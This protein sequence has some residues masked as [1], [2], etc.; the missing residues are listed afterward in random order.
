MARRLIWSDEFNEPGTPNPSKWTHELGAGGWGNQELQHYTN[1]LANAQVSNGTLK[2]NAI[3]ESFSGSDYT[4]ARLVTK[5]RFN[6]TYGIVEA[7]IKLPA[8]T[9]IWPAFWML[10]SNYATA[11][12]PA[13]G[14]I[15]IMEFKGREPTTLYLSLIHI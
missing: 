5:E 6:F 12:W 7:R 11:S 15:D 10:G 4:S 3:K 14:E 2:I 1:R 13:C 9:G 8:G